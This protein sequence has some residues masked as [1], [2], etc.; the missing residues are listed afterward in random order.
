M[1][2]QNFAHELLAAA[3]HALM[4]DA[5]AARERVLAVSASALAD[6]PGGP[7]DEEA[8]H[9]FRV[10][11]RRMRTL[12]R[13][14]RELWR[15]K[16]L[17]RIEGEIRYHA[18]ATGALRDEEVLRET[19]AALDLPQEAHAEVGGW[20]VRRARAVRKEHAEVTRLLRDGPPRRAP[21]L[22]NGKRIRPLERTFHALAA[23]LDGDT[24]RLVSAVD[25]GHEVLDHAAHDVA[26]WAL[27]DVGDAEAMH[28]LR[29]RYKRLRYTAELFTAPL[30]ARATHLAKHATRMQRHLGEL[31]DIDQAILTLSRA[32]GLGAAT[33]GA[34]LA[35]LRACRV[36]CAAKVEPRLV[37][38]RSL[39]DRGQDDEPPTL[40]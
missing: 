22:P 40:V 32:R 12:L 30:G 14:A 17:A 1:N 26:T 7:T 18:Q 3:L 20:L 4:T 25:L 9:D 36:T 15:R 38:A 24:P 28:E 33:K 5:R 21:T 34:V 2:T 10:A 31:H 23:R 11:L 37:E 19:L 16:R 27:R 13:V 29:I 39:V 35:A 8:L 6:T